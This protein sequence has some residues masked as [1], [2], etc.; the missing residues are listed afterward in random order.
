M[1]RLNTLTLEGATWNRTSSMNLARKVR[2]LGVEFFIAASSLVCSSG[3]AFCLFLANGTLSHAQAPTLTANFVGW[4]A[5]DAG[6]ATFDTTRFGHPVPSGHVI[7]VLAHW[8]DQT[9]SASVSDS[10]GNKY[11]PL[12]EPLNA[13]PTDRI[14]AWYAKNLRAGT[15]LSVTI[16][17]SQKTRSFSVVDAIELAGLDQAEPLIQSRAATG[18]GT[19]Q[20]SGSL[21][22]NSVSNCLMI[23]LFGYSKYALPY[24][25]GEGFLMNAYEASTIVEQAPCSAIAGHA[26]TATSSSAADWVAIA[27]AFRTAVP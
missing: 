2:K 6:A 17:F 21:T 4:T 1:G 7:V 12:S 18:N 27:A 24:K 26:A 11:L 19:N 14:Q 25:A 15:D 5:G 13:G 8:N 10:R 20:N 9:V 3:L 22:L 16:H 23:G